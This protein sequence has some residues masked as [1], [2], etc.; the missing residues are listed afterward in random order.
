[1]ALTQSSFQPT[2]R[3]THHWQRHQRFSSKTC[4][5]PSGKLLSKSTIWSS[6]QNA[7]VNQKLSVTSWAAC[8]EQQSLRNHWPW[9]SMSKRQA[10][11]VQ[12]L[13]FRSWKKI[14]RRRSE[15]T[16]ETSQDALK[17]EKSQLRWCAYLWRIIYCKLR[18]TCTTSV[19]RLT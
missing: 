14:Y 5:R 16:I 9:N 10:N 6:T 4:F 7:M 12:R 11:R 15:F 2:S 3:G 17:R 18:S 19:T 13:L 1:M 8:L